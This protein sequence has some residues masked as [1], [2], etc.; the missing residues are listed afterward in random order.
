[1]GKRK[2]SKQALELGGDKGKK[3]I[4]GVKGQRVRCFQGFVG[5]NGELAARGER[6]QKLHQPTNVI[7]R[8]NT[9]RMNLLYLKVLP[10]ACDGSHERIP[11][12][13]GKANGA[14]GA[15]SGDA[16]EGRGARGKGRGGKGANL[17]PFGVCPGGVT[18]EEVRVCGAGG[19]EFC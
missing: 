7:E 15:A 8:Q 14:G 3:E 16:N 12:V 9:A 6:S 4:S 1:M 18:E 11:G 2:G 13:H 17:C 5:E 19:D 10:K